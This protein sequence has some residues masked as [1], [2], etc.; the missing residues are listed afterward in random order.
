VNHPHTRTIPYDDVQIILEVMGGTRRCTPNSPIVRRGTLRHPQA[1]PAPR[2]SSEVGQ[3]QELP[4]L[5]TPIPKRSDGI[6]PVAQEGLH[7]A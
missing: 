3:K 7:K 4:S 2:F 5:S 6:L 1:C